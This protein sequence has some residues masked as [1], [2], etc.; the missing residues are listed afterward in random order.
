M[1]THAN[2]HSSNAVSRASQSCL[3][4][5]VGGF[6]LPVQ[7]PLTQPHCPGIKGLSDRAYW[8]GPPLIRGVPPGRS[9]F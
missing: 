1:V 6:Y 7:G 9:G 4:C 8:Q 5:V 2:L 3:M